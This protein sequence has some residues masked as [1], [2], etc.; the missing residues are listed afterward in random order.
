MLITAIGVSL[1]IE[2]LAQITW[3]FGGQKFFG[4]DPMRY[5]P[6][7]NSGVSIPFFQTHLGISVVPKRS[8][9]VLKGTT[10]VTLAALWFIVQRTR[11]GKAMRAVSVNYDAARLMG[12]NTDWVISFTFVLGVDAGGDWG[13]PVGVE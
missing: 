12:I 8:L 2:Y 13:L 4:P 9:V 6:I 10:T 5:Q 3:T 11:I 1:L 7:V